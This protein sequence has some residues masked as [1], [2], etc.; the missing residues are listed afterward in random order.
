[1][2]KLGTCEDLPGRAGRLTKNHE[3]RREKAEDGAAQE[4]IKHQIALDHAER[5]T[6][7][8]KMKEEV[9][10]AKLAALLAKQQKWKLRGMLL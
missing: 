4:H 8:A 2:C 6:C 7:F 10:A 9:E 3:E 5:A 1:M